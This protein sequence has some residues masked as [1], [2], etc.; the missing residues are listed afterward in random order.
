MTA[1]ANEAKDGP[2]LFTVEP[3][4]GNWRRLLAKPYRLC[5]WCEAD[6]CQHPV[7][8][9][10][11]GVYEFKATR[12]WVQRV[13]PY[14]NFVAGVLRML[15]PMVAPSVAVLFGPEA[16][17]KSGLEAHLDLMR[18]ATA[19][20]LPDIEMDDPSRLRRGA[21]SEDE[22]SGILALHAFLREEDPNHERLGLR[23]LPTYT[24]DYLWLCQ[25][26]YEQRQPKI[27]ERI[28]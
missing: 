15:L 8:E 5:L 9:E 24:G 21:L 26:H 11:K 18:Q 1:M 4:D 12:E 13:A 27:P 20:L 22:R 28:E 17:D 3:L 19:E 14:A 7:F 25:S 16:L 2:R 23:R 6:G 10:G